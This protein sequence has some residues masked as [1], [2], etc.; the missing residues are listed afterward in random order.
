MSA[1][2]QIGMRN[3]IAKIFT[4]TL[5]SNMEE[6]VSFMLPAVVRRQLEEIIE[7]SNS[8]V[9]KFVAEKLREKLGAK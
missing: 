9:E 5:R 4:E 2:D 8:A 7:Q 3:E 1:L 6:F